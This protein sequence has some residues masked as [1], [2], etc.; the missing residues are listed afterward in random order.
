MDLGFEGGFDVVREAIDIKL[1]GDWIEATNE[2]KVTL[3]R[4][5]FET[6]F[7]NDILEYAKSAWVPFFT[8]RGT[9]KKIF[10]TQSIVD[11][12][13]K[14]KQNESVFPNNRH[15]RSERWLSATTNNES[16]RRIRL[17]RDFFI[18]IDVV[19]GGFP[20]QD[21]SLSGKRLG[22]NS[23]KNHHGEKNDTKTDNPSIE[24]RGILYVWMKEVIEITKPRIFVAENVK[25]LTSLGNVKQIIE[26]DFRSVDKGYIVVPAQ[27]LNAKEYGI[28]QNRERLIFIG[29][30]KR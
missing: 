18:N 10:H 24:N 9:D 22:F 3:A 27:I 26:N 4:T 14:H 20:C 11:L 5:S 29:L 25:G 7:A 6:V 23:H 2:N 28:P 1:N 19:T 12:V 13:K 21:F 17:W 30:S 8:A 16:L 15:G